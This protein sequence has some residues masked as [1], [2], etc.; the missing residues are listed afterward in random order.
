MLELYPLPCAIAELFAQVSTSG[1]LTL[2]DRYGLLAVLLYEAASEE[3]L[4]C[5]DRILYALRKGR[6]QIIHELS[7][8]R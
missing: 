3:E 8:I 4:Y 5:I 1:K 7:T 2:A 6:V